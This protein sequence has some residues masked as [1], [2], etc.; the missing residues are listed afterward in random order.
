[1]TVFEA[2]RDEDRAIIF[3]DEID[4]VAGEREGA[5]EA[6]RRVVAQLLTLMDGFERDEN[7]V[8]VAATNRPEDVDDALRRPGRF[9]WEISFDRPTREDREKIL[10]AS[11]RHLNLA[12]AP[13]FSVLADRTEGW[14]SAHLAAIWRE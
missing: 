10:K 6:S 3:F 4:S 14:S 12:D 13:P 7:V 2:A 9:D 5:H 8:V 1:R 11:A